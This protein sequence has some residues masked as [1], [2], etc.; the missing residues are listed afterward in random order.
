MKLGDRGFRYLSENWYVA[1]DRTR[2]AVWDHVQDKGASQDIGVEIK[3]TCRGHRCNRETDST[4]WLH[5]IALVEEIHCVVY[6][7][8]GLGLQLG[9]RPLTC[10]SHLH[11]H[12]TFHFRL[13]LAQLIS[14]IIAAGGL[15]FNFSPLLRL[16]PS[17]C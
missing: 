15:Q 13:S 8:L 11:P 17:P 9:P 10:P 5:K 16:L 4:K 3:T 7:L 6:S 1:L 14:Y 12:M 2:R